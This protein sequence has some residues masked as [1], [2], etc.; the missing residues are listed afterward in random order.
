MSEEN[1]QTV[2]NGNFTIQANTKTG[3]MIT[4]SGYT[5]AHDTLSEVNSRVDM[6]MLVLAR[7]EAKAEIEAM[8]VVREARLIALRNSKDAVQ[9]MQAVT[10]E[11]AKMA[12]A[13]KAAVHNHMET[14]TALQREIADLEYKITERSKVLE[15]VE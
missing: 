13:K 11:G 6:H 12:T 10:A 9:G 8:R 5:Y 7:Q 14:I 2:V 3:K 4:M 1:V 15:V